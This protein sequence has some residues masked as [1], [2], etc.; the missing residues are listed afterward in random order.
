MIRNHL[1]VLHLN[2]TVANVM[3]FQD[4]PNKLPCTKIA[5]AGVVSLVNAGRSLT[6]VQPRIVEYIS[7]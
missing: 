2:L 4:S 6:L 7:S 5:D 1:Y 3:V